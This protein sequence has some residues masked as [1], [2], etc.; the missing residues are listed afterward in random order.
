MLDS[1]YYFSH[2]KTIEEYTHF[3]VRLKK[4]NDAVIINGGNETLESTKSDIT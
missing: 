4:H 2:K 3:S 1:S